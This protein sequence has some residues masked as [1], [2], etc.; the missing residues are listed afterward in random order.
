MSSYPTLM[1]KFKLYLLTTLLTIGLSIPG[2]AQNFENAKFGGDFLSVGGG[3]RALGMGGAQTAFVNDITSG[4]WNPAGLARMENLELAYMH[5]QRFAGIV[6]YDY[7]ALGLPVRNSE[8]VFGISFFRQG[9]DGIKNTM[10]AWDF[11]NNRP[12]SNPADYF[13]E[14]S[15]ADM[16]LFLTYAA[17]A[18]DNLNWG[19]SAKVI[20]HRLGPFA[21]AWGYSLDVGMQYQTSDYFF[22]VNVMDI[23]TMMKFW[24]VDSEELA[25]LGDE[26]MFGG[27]FGSEMPEGQNERVLPTVK[28]GLGRIF[29]FND[30]QLT[31][32]VDADIR[33]EGR[34][35]YFYNIGHMSIEP[36]V[37][38]ELGYH[39]LVFLRTGVTDFHLDEEGNHYVSPTIGAGLKVG[40]IFLDY[41]FSSFA[42]IASDLGFTHRISLK[43]SL[44]SDVFSR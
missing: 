29:D 27:E 28:L 38:V 37:G 11:E 15:A 43:V 16:A 4:Y 42:G 30:F 39:D 9:I 7:G 23:T 1:P 19:V 25:P 3:A 44:D 32:A 13:T 2:F 36:H 21:D 40:S 31:T 6:N 35:T 18:T 17:A 33:F 14:F 20:N 34:Q 22:G 24:S 41:G 8:G 12:R 26:D 5:S 10:E